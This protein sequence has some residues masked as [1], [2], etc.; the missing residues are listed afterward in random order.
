MLGASRSE[1]RIRNGVA[2][3]RRGGS[4]GSKLAAAMLTAEERRERARTA[5]WARWNKPK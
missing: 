3:G 4:K 5:A 1:G 2:L